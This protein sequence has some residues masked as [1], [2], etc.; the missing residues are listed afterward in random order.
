MI[1]IQAVQG[2]EAWHAARAKC[3]NASEA[4]A[5][6]GVSKY[7]TRT[8]LLRQKATGIV[9]EVDA[10][11]QA[12]FDMG[13]EVEAKARPLVEAIIAEELY[14]IVATDD[15]GKY[16]ASSD[17]ATM[18]CNIGFEH[19]LWNTSLAKLV[20]A[21]EVPESHRGQLDHQ[22]LVFGFDKIIFVVSDGT[23]EN[24]VH[25]WYYPQT[26]RIAALKAGWDQF[27]K[28]LAA[29]NPE[30]KE[31]KPI[32]H[33]SPI[34]NLP[35]L[36]IEVTGRVTASNLVEFK[37]AATA[38]ISSIKT[39]LVTDQDF[40]DATAA[41]KYLKD[42]E[43]SAK[44]AK[45]NALDQTASIAELHRALD[46]VAGMAAT[47][48]KALDKKITEEKDSRKAEIVIAASRA[49]GEHCAALGH[50]VGVPV[51]SAAS[52]G[53]AIKGLKSLDSMRDKVSAALANAKIESSATADRI[54]ANIKSLECEGQSW[55]FL[56]P[57]LQAVC[58]KASDDFAALLA[59]RKA[60]H[61]AAESA[62]IEKIRAEEKAKAEAAA[63]AKVA[64][65]ARIAKAEADAKAATEKAEADRLAT[66]EIRKIDEQRKAQA[67][68]RAKQL[69]EE[70]NAAMP[71]EAPK[72]HIE[73]VKEAA[74]PVRNNDM[75]RLQFRSELI[76]RIDAMNAVQMANLIAY[77]DAQVI[78]ERMAA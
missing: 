21:G 43:D 30:A 29:Y 5:M 65:E 70:A 3:F 75:K 23:P 54:E 17:G 12:R 1:E 64:E 45:Q 24:M 22:F 9:P 67:M 77:L 72:E 71:D 33:A 78:R 27:E 56:F 20:S 44:R 73:P 2:S 46:E 42:V 52:F 50:R 7:M 34:D 49:L 41:V 37:A 55:R 32:L 26:E 53:D 18:L 13:H 60:S 35:A 47:V 4:P 28:D 61:A 57:D 74:S 48:R 10:A 38:V 14:P 39:E 19:K 11:T 51:A 76:A 6:L 8:E 68:E 62:R 36:F 25:C 40:V 66:E 63:A 16:L 15:S 58:T 59:A 69:A 31:S